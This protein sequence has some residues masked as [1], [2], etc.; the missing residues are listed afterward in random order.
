[1]LFVDLDHDSYSQSGA[2]SAQ[3]NYSRSR[4]PGGDAEML[5]EPSDVLETTVTSTLLQ[6]TNRTEVTFLSPNQTMNNQGRLNF[7]SVM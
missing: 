1:M 5:F 2:P 3:P 4:S 6:T 7:Y